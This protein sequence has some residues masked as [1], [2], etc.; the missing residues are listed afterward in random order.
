MSLPVNVVTSIVA[1]L[2]SCTAVVAASSMHW[3]IVVDVSCTLFVTSNSSAALAISVTTVDRYSR[4]VVAFSVNSSAVLVT[5]MAVP[6]RFLVACCK[7]LML[8]SR[9]DVDGLRCPVITLAIFSIIWFITM[10]FSMNAIALI[11]STKTFEST[12]D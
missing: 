6:H 4:E 10:F 2:I 12:G 11:L 1:T 3:E 9:C 7:S 8:L 5:P